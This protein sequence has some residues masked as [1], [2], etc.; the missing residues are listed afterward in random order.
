M[1]L[2]AGWNQRLEIIRRVSPLIGPVLLLRKIFE[3]KES[4]TKKITTY[5]AEKI[6]LNNPVRSQIKGM[7]TSSFRSLIDSRICMVK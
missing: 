3:C 2:P 5:F 7:Y 1:G 6:S 4:F